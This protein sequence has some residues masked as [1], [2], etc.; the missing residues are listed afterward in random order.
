MSELYDGLK[1]L[2][3]DAAVK[4]EKALATFVI[5]PDFRTRLKDSLEG[6]KM[7]IAACDRRNAEYRRALDLA[8]VAKPEA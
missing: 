3:I 8:E 6:L 4:T 5:S 2:L 7:E 1:M